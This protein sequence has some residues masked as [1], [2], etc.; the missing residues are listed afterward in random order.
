MS[1]RASEYIPRQRTSSF[2]SHKFLRYV[3]VLLWQMSL[4]QFYNH[5][6]SRC[7]DSQYNQVDIYEPSPLFPKVFLWPNLCPENT[8]LFSMHCQ[9][10]DIYPIPRN[11]RHLHQNL[12]VPASLHPRKSGQFFR[13][14]LTV[15][16]LNNTFLLSSTLHFLCEQC[17]FYN[18][19]CWAYS[20]F[21]LHHNNPDNAN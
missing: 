20:W 7:G 19:I 13:I 3:F 10:Q 18:Q 17:L 5:H 9:G 11:T 15:L 16:W 14:W 8:G 4:P 2:L 21:P 6:T 12:V 1:H